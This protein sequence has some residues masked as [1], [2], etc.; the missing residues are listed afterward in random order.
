MI[1][2]RPSKYTAGTSAAT[3]ETMSQMPSSNIPTFF[4]KFMNIFLSFYV[5]CECDGNV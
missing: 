4:E 1:V 2:L 3:P 5:D